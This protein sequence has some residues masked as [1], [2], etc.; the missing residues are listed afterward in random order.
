MLRTWWGMPCRLLQVL[1][2]VLAHLIA[3]LTPPL[4]A[5]VVVRAAGFMRCLL[6]M[7]RQTVNCSIRR[8]MPWPGRQQCWSLQALPLKS[9]NRSLGL[10]RR[11]PSLSPHRLMRVLLR[12]TAT[13][14]ERL[15]WA[16]SLFL[17]SK[18]PNL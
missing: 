13:A 6:G 16:P 3:P 9:R 12:F 18:L 11:I 2:Q 14:P 10:Q 7:A 1:R 15:G 8:V 4:S 17:R 5:A